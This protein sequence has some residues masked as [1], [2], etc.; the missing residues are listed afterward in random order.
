MILSRFNALLAL[1]AVASTAFF[2]IQNESLVAD[3]TVKVTESKVG[4][5]P[6]GEEAKITPIKLEDKVW[7]GKISKDETKS[8]EWNLL[9][10]DEGKFFI[11]TTASAYDR[12]LKL[13]KILGEYWVNVTIKKGEEGKVERTFTRPK[14][15][16]RKG[17]AEGPVISSWYKT[18]ENK[19][20]EQE[21]T[22]TKP[23]SHIHPPPS[24]P[25]YQSLYLGEAPINLLVSFEPNPKLSEPTKLLLIIS[26]AVPRDSVEVSLLV[27][28]VNIKVIK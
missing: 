14:V 1:V 17:T 6:Q 15:T 10:Q 7:H 11:Q 16:P 27:N 18:L 19:A 23:K 2:F 13:W 9:F 4:Q 26:S 21:T 24:W 5:A 28:T 25:L 12:Q 20:V 3:P 22:Q 8:F